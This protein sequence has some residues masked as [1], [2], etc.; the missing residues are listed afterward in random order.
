ML[1][2]MPALSVSAGARDWLET[3]VLAKWEVSPAA[4][5]CTCMQSYLIQRT[6]HKHAQVQG[7]QLAWC[8]VLPASDA[9][10]TSGSWEPH[11]C[12]L[13]WLGAPSQ[14]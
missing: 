8:C 4:D 9:G 12:L 3:F 14:Q 11:Q 6:L 7:Q 13:N 5:P 2:S 1:A 10:Q